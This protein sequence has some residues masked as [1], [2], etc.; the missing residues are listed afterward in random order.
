MI[1]CSSTVTLSAEETVIEYGWMDTFSFWD[2]V[3]LIQ[4]ITSLC[5]HICR[6]YVY[7]RL[8]F[9]HHLFA[10]QKLD[11]RKMASDTSLT[12]LGVIMRP[13]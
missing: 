11:K 12:N 13:I 4:L 6:F 2:P 1:G 10:R 9:T 8:C 7:M 5:K 3:Y